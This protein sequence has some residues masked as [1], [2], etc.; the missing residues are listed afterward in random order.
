MKDKYPAYEIQEFPSR[1]Q[2]FNKEETRKA[3]FQN[4]L[5]QIIKDYGK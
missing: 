2:I 5:N 1:F 3:Y 4:L